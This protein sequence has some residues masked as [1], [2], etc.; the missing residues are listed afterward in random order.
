MAEYKEVPTALR[1]E[2]L[3]ERMFE[4]STIANMTVK[5]RKYYDKSIMETW[6]D[7]QAQM[8]FAVKNAM[9]QGIEQGATQRNFEIA[10]AMLALGL[11]RDIICKSTG[12]TED[13]IMRLGSE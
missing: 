2:I 4:A 12:L 10:R 3:V 7:R 1:D 11:E 5:Q 13:E 6:I 9:K 8:D